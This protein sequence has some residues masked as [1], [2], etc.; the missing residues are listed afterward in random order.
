MPLPICSAHRIQAKDPPSHGSAGYVT[1]INPR[2]P[3]D[4]INCCYPCWGPLNSLNGYTP[5]INPTAHS[6]LSAK[7]RS[8]PCPGG[9]SPLK[10]VICLAHFQPSVTWRVTPAYGRSAA[11][12]GLKAHPTALDCRS[13]SGHSAADPIAPIGCPPMGLLQK[14]LRDWVQQGCPRFPARPADC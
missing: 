9:I 13:H 2:T 4:Q 7:L 3:K 8:N 11:R 6:P 1:E 12:L 5:D 10:S 14:T